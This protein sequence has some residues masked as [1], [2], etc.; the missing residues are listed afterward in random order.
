MTSTGF[1]RRAFLAVCS[2]AG[3]GS[4]LFPGVLWGMVLAASEQQPSV[5]T[6]PAT[7]ETKPPRITRAMIDDA[8]A[9][10]GLTIAD[11]YKDMMLRDLNDQV[12]SYEAIRKLE[13]KNNEQLALTFNPVL[14][15]M[16]IATAS[17]R[18]RMSAAVVTRA[19]KNLED[20]AFSTMRQLAELIK[21][22]KISSVALTEMYLERLRRY[23][24][25]LK[26]AITLTTERAMAQAK[27]ADRD[28]AAGRYRGPLHGI[29]WGAKDLLAVKGYPTTWGAGGFEKQL[30]EEDATVVQRL[31]RAGAVLIAKFTLGALAMGDKWFGGMTRNPWRPEDQGS[32]GSSAGSAS[33]VAAGCVG[34]ALGSETLGSIS[35]PSTRCGVT[36]L[37]PTFGFLPRTGAMTLCWSWD[38]LGPIGRSVE[39]CALVLDAI[40]GPDGKD[41]GCIHPAAFNWDAS[42]DWR[43]LRVGYLKSAFEPPKK[44]EEPPAPS[45]E[46][47]SAEEKKSKEEEELKDAERRA[48]RAYDLPFA[49]AA[50]AQLQRMGAKLIPVEL[51]KFPYGPCI[52]GLSAEAAAAFD[53]LT[54]SG[55]DRLLTEQTIEDW[56]NQFRTARFIP[57]VDYI[58]A[59]RARLRLMYEFAELFRKVDI[60]VTPSGG[61]QLVATNL[62]GHPAVILPNGFRG[63]DA[64]KQHKYEDGGGPGTPVSLTFLGNL[65]DD[66]RLCA[67]ARAYQEVTGFHRKHPPLPRE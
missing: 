29:P 14:P 19:P 7:P 8:A 41:I 50:L 59:N 18:L 53:H 1:D 57:A 48:L 9:I 66:A 4:T 3:V 52:I 36:G 33:A 61:Q 16:K 55:R 46:P 35:S 17:V 44:E 49:Q 23:D 34:F 5:T 32:S 63:P 39:D 24:P 30:I 21:T 25:L 20:V 42:Y 60:I 67:F 10:A 40:H 27:D 13:L 62:T 6:P 12:A 64:P 22:R 54:R 65:F 43:K 51:P 2:A 11:E 47:L 45:P 28:L 31:D 56:P 15:G 58:N 26:F 38:K 37:R